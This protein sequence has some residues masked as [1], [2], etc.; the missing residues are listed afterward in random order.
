MSSNFEFIDIKR[1]EPETKSIKVRKIEFGEIYQTQNLESV[2][3]Q[4]SRCLDCGNPYCE[5]KC[6]LHNYIPDWLKL[7]QIGSIHEAADLCHETNSFPEICGRIC[8]QEK[9][10][11][12]ACTLNTGY[13]AVTIGQIEKY[14]T[15]KALSEGWKPKKLVESSSKKT[16]SIIGAG[17]AGL[18]CAEN[19]IRRGVK[20]IVYD[21]YS[22]I[23]G[24][25]TYGIPEFKLEKNIVIKRREIL[26]ELGVEFV[27]NFEVDEKRM[28][29]IEK[30]SDAIFL[31]LGT[32]E[33]IKG[34]ING[35]SK[36]GVV[37]ALPYLIKNTEYLMS[38]EDAENIDFRDKKV[39]VLGGGDTAMDCVRTAIRQQAK[40][41]YCVYRRDKENMPGSVKEI[42]HAMEEGVEFL[43][44]SQPLEIIGNG[45]VRQLK[46]GKTKLGKADG[47]GRRKPVLIKNSEKI[48]DVDKLV[49]AFGYEADPQS[50]IAE[51][52]IKVSDRG[53]ISL[54]NENYKYQTS[55][56]KFFAG[57]DM[58][59]GSSLA[60]HAIAHG[61]DAAK[62]I[63][64]FLET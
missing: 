41:V 13:E 4:S 33:S 53:L 63:I 29:E 31:G 57:G 22:Q 21:R 58:I 59:I 17:P 49:I 62:E 12:G 48:L 34:N 5:W 56:P 47:S 35:L 40:S 36:D 24:L 16:V 46:I 37:E 39:V 43:F 27:L 19:L 1:I 3:E 55:N 42:K 44:N 32:Y 30:N 28:N 10:C 11:E 54:D 9:L 38:E 25:L 61:R 50:F 26:E 14:I 64:K 52:N 6:P 7:A 23:G 18:A 45:T 8:P 60:V 15:D 2:K 20:C 51:N